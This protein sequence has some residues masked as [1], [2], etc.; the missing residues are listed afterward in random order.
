MVLIVIVLVDPLEAFFVSPSFKLPTM[1]DSQPQLIL[2]IDTAT[3]ISAAGG[4]IG[5]VP[6]CALGRG[7]PAQCN[8]CP[9]AAKMV[10]TPVLGA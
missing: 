8:H 5:L 10:I 9:C 7:V 1:V 6:T 4:P 2:I 3:F